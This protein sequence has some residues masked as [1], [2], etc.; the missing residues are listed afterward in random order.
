MRGTRSSQAR[1][2]ALMR[3]VSK[4]LVPSVT[5]KGD[6]YRLKGRDLGRGAD[7][8]ADEVTPQTG[9]TAKNGRDRHWHDIE[10]VMALAK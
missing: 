6:S 2:Q 3:P 1:N 5:L 9:P 10:E 4:W 8:T 7:R